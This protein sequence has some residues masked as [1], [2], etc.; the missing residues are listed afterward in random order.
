MHTS[1]NRL[2]TSLHNQGFG[3]ERTAQ[4]VVQ[5]QGA[6]QGVYDGVVNQVK[7][8][9]RRVKNLRGSAAMLDDCEAQ[10]ELATVN[11]LELG[12]VRDVAKKAM[13]N[14]MLG[15]TESYL[16]MPN[17][18]RVLKILYAACESVRGCGGVH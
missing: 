9:P 13:I 16:A 4:A 14:E 5:L 6:V 1:V 8:E 3:N 2:S 15:S 11:E 7:P 17:R 18:A 10:L 12:N